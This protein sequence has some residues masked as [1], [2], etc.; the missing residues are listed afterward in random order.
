MTPTPTT[1]AVLPFR[2]SGFATLSDGLD[3]AARGETGCN[4]FSARGELEQTLPYRE[5]RERAIDLAPRAWP[6]WASPAAR[7]SRSS[8]TPRPS[9][10]IFFF[11]CQYAGLVPVPLPLSVNF[12]GR[13]AYE[14]RLAGMIRTARRGCGRVGRS[15]RPAATA[16]AGST[17]NLVGT[18]DEFR[19]CPRRGDLRPLS[20]DEPCYIQF[21]SRQHEL[22]ARRAGQPT[23]A[24]RATPARSPATACS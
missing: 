21:S 2:R 1:N 6:G 24:G 4:F 7:A 19:D 15:D 20:A 9:S 10:W 5:L 13:A 11:A 14:E 17:V 16:A 3:Y 18:H 22:S 8:P 12:G 23:G